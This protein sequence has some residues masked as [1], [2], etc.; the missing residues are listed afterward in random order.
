VKTHF[1]EDD[2]ENC[3]AAQEE[4]EKGGMGARKRARVRGGKE[5]ISNALWKTGMLDEEIMRNGAIVSPK[6]QRMSMGPGDMDALVVPRK[7]TNANHLITPRKAGRKIPLM[8]GAQVTV[9]IQTSQETLILSP[10]KL[11]PQKVPLN[12]QEIAQDGIK[13]PSQPSPQKIPLN[14]MDQNGD[15]ATVPAEKPVQRRKS[16]RR[17]TRRLTRGATP[18][19]PPAG[20]A[21]E[22]LGNSASEPVAHILETTTQPASESESLVLEAASKD[23]ESVGDVLDM[24]ELLVAI[25]SQSADQRSGPEVVQESVALEAK[26]QSLPESQHEAELYVEC[27]PA[28]LKVLKEDLKEILLMQHDDLQAQASSTSQE[29]L[30]DNAIEP[31]TILE[32]PPTAAANETPK[33]QPSLLNS[34]EIGTE[35]QFSSPTKRSGTPRQRRKTPQRRGSRRSTRSTRASSVPPEDQPAHDVAEVKNSQSTSSP[36]KS[37]MAKTPTKKARKSSGQ[38]LVVIEKQVSTEAHMS[39]NAES[40]T[41]ASKQ[42]VEIGAQAQ[43]LESTDTEGFVTPRLSESTPQSENIDAL[44]PITKSSSSGS[45]GAEA[46]GEGPLLTMTATVEEEISTADV[47]NI[48]EGIIFEGVTAATEGLKEDKDISSPLKLSQPEE[49]KHNLDPAFSEVREGSVEALELLEP[50][51][52]S[53]ST[54]KPLEYSIEEPADELPG[55]STPNPSTTELVETISENAPANTFDHDDTDMLRN[56]LTRVKANKAAKAGTSIPKRKRS[57]PHSPLRLPLG[58]VDSAL[59]PSSPKSKDEFDVSL[60]TE[61]AAKRKLDDAELGDDEATQPKSI[62]RSGRTRLPVK[63]APLAAPSFIPVR[64]LGQDGDNTVTLRRNEEKELAALT[65]VNTRKNK[66]GAQLPIQVLAKQAEEK[67]DPASRQR[68]LKEVFDEKALKQKKGKKGKTVV[69]AEDLAQFQTEEGK[70]TE[71]DREPEKEKER[72]VPVEE[73]KNAVKVGV[74]SKMTLGMAVNG[75]PAPKRK[76]RGRS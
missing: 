74:R 69:W 44:E 76:M 20:P 37:R 5:N 32:Q 18:E 75:T 55:S 8:E 39:Q 3:E 7:R 19:Q 47:V 73:K 11:S 54:E 16:L 62:R 46:E 71:L 63:A 48:Q 53:L 60:P 72:P 70:T 23:S 27:P 30:L 42:N 29:G 21:E 51:S 35:T 52:I 25:P 57:L 10:A 4:L 36:V 56:F 67:E 66:G 58:I 64:R 14:D 65:R 43:Q 33:S 49:L 40:T 59:S 24:G 50:I 12:D 28:A 17:S 1:K 45:S 6:K 26:E 13:R 61:R 15:G 31:A 41:P 38:D 2:K 34:I 9:A 68:A 22:M